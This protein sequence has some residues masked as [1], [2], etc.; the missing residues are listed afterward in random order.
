MSLLTLLT[1]FIPKLPKVCSLKTSSKQ[2]DRDIQRSR[3][4][5]KIRSKSNTMIKKIA[6]R[7]N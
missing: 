5:A 2:T 6:L 7:P 1:F 4:F 3:Y